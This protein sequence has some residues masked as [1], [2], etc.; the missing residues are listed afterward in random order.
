MSFE[1]LPSQV[2]CQ[3]GARLRMELEAR[4]DSMRRVQKWQA[5]NV[6]TGV[7]QK[8]DGHT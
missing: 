3:V 6:W 8:L 2:S 7:L 4:I 1:L 5:V